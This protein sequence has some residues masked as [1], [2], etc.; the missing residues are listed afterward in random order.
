MAPEGDWFG[1]FDGFRRMKLVA[2]KTQKDLTMGLEKL[3]DE[4]V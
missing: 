3:E 2:I 1:H 4:E